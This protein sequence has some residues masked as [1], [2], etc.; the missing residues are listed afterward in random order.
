MR[1]PRA[2]ALYSGAACVITLSDDAFR[3]YLHLLC[4]QDYAQLGVVKGPRLKIMAELQ[5][6]FLDVAVGA[7][8]VGVCVRFV[9]FS[10]LFLACQITTG[11]CSAELVHHALTL[12][13]IV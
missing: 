3:R 5:R 12:S 13:L 2:R 1:V 10:V 8:Q 7:P 9:R 11:G 6:V 4:A